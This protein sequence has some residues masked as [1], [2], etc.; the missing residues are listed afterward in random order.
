MRSNLYQVALILVTPLFSNG[1]SGAIAVTETLAV[2]LLEVPGGNLRNPEMC[3]T[4]GKGVVLKSGT[5]TA[6]TSIGRSSTSL[7]FTITFTTSGLANVAVPSP[8]STPTSYVVFGAAPMSS[9]LYQVALILVT[10]LFSN[11]CSGAIAVRETLAVSLL[12]V[13]GG[14][15]RNPVMCNTAGEGVVLK[16]G[17]ETAGTSIGRSSTSLLFTITFTT[18]GLANVAVPSPRSTPTSYVV[19]GSAAS[20]SNLYQVVLILVTPLFSNGCSGAIAVTETLAVSLLV[21]PGGN[22]RNPE[23]CNT[24]GE[25]VVLK[26][27]TETASTSIGRSSTSL[28]FTIAF[29]T[30]G[31]AN[32]AVPSPRSTPTSYVVF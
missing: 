4:A 31:L 12:V 23:M 21:V 13:S 16:S 3:N 32:V 10:P 14:N 2:S 7:L 28:L 24:T 1:C 25:G 6:S 27:G 30:S 19:F 29:T 11:G 9:N 5:E 17:T 26:S 22:L 15:L 20:R 8:R 18:S